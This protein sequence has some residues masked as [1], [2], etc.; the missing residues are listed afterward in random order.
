M[1]VKLNTLRPRQNGRRFADDIFKCIFL[2]DNVRISIKFSLKFVPKGLINNIP[3]LVQISWPTHICVTRPQWVNYTQSFY[4]FVVNHARNGEVVQSMSCVSNS[5]RPSDSYM[6][7]YPML[8][9]I[10]IMVRHLIDLD[11]Q[12]KYMLTNAIVQV[13]GANMGPTWVLAAPDGPHV[14]P[15]N[16]A[17]KVLSWMEAIITTV[18]WLCFSTLPS[19]SDNRPTCIEYGYHPVPCDFAVDSAGWKAGRGGRYE[20]VFH[21]CTLWFVM[22]KST[23]IRSE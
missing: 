20:G 5:P 17:I 7:P 1:C 19:W 21:N 6:R 11:M 15:M 14:G 16:L 10:P 2:N 23:G 8:S 18:L 13:H 12:H 3:A 22:M 4:T 9:L